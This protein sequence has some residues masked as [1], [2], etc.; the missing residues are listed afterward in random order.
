VEA[1]RR[2]GHLFAFDIPDEPGTRTWH[3]A[4]TADD[5]GDSD[6]APVPT[7]L[8]RAFFDE[9]APWPWPVTVEWDDGIARYAYLAT[10]VVEIPKPRRRR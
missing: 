1:L 2:T 4:R 5:S 7:K 3:Y 8:Y 6:F 10:F 9:E